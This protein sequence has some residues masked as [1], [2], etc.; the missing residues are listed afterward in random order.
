MPSMVGVCCVKETLCWMISEILNPGLEDETERLERLEPEIRS[1][2]W[3]CLPDT[4]YG[5]VVRE[6]TPST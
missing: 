1:L 4:V 2:F 3:T 6:I 5:W